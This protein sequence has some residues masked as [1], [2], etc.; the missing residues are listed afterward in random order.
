MTTISPTA[1]PSISP[2]CVKNPSR[3]ARG[4]SD[5]GYGALFEGAERFAARL[6]GA[7][8]RPG[9]RVAVQ[10]EKSIEAVQ[11]Y[12]GTVLAGGIFLPLNTAYTGAEVSYFLTD[13]TPAVVVCDPSREAEIAPLIGTAT[14]FTLD[15][16][17]QGSLTAGL[18]DAP[19]LCCRR[20]RP[21]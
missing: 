15:A 7:G 12:I 2:S 9:D 18:T 21:R 10:V 3:R 16:D 17:G 11:L 4:L 5:V 20:A 6:L 13:A 1:L 19:Q 14:L 8:L